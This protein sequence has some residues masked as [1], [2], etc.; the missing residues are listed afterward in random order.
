MAL[1]SDPIGLTLGPLYF[2]WPAGRLADF[3]ARIADEAPVDR[4]HLGEV[5]C[6]KRSPLAIDTLITAAERLE[7]AG[8]TVV[9]SGL[10][11]P[12]NK[13]ERR[14]SQELMQ[15][16]GLVEINDFGALK[17]RQDA[18]FVAGPFLNVYNEAALALLASMGCERWCPRVEL[19][20]DAIS[21]VA[22]GNPG[23]TV[24]L[25]AF[26]RLPLAHSGRCYHARQNGLTRDSCQY[27]CEKDPDGAGIETLDGIP[28]L[29]YNGVQ[30]LSHAVHVSPFATSMLHQCGVNALRLSPQ[31]G[32]MVAIAQ[33]WR[34][35]LDERADLDGLLG[36]VRTEMPGFDLV[37]G[38]LAGRPGREWIAP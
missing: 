36:A 20:L 37:S 38:Y 2:N 16:E 19:S 26:G 33:A 34:D 30:T 4:V 23:V 8:K 1:T 6:G 17:D 35:F 28:F 15:S 12:V 22:A 32:D 27:V 29:A 24:E 25:F 31:S 10:I 11:S 14:M 3:Y 5:V 21:A 18:P 7:R 9:W 13:R